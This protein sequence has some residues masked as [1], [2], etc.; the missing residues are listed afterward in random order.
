MSQTF[1]LLVTPYY[2][3][4][5]QCY[6][7]VITVNVVPQG[8]LKKIV[9]RIKIGN[10]QRFPQRSNNSCVSE[11]NSC[12]LVLGSLLNTGLMCDN[13][14][15]TPDEIPTLFSYL[16]SNGYQIDTQLTNMMSA[17]MVRMS[18]DDKIVCFAT[19]YGANAPNFV[20]IK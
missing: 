15:M 19:Y 2:D 11:R 1:A 4:C 12:T 5:S 9:R 14:Y 17:N 8:P 10:M 20:Y 7:N 13:Q 18:T 16:T 3:S 6:Y